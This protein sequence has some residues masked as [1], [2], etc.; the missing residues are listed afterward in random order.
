VKSYDYLAK[1]Y[2][3]KFVPQI[4]RF[5]KNSRS[6]DSMCDNFVLSRTHTDFILSL[7][8]PVRLAALIDYAVHCIGL[9]NQFFHLYFHV[10]VRWSIV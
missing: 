3:P 9:S 4:P 8:L 2:F 6:E 7:L 5:W 10:S 1:S